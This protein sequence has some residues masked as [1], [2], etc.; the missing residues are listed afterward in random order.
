VILGVFL[1]ASCQKEIP[2]LK[3]F[4]DKRDD[5]IYKTIKIGTQTWMAENLAYLPSVRPSKYGLDYSPYYY[6]YGYEGTSVSDA[7]ATTNYTI[8]GVLYNWEAAKTA[9]PNGWHLPSDTE[10]TVLT[11]YLANN[12][13]GYEGSGDD[14]AKSMASPFDWKSS[15]NEYAPGNDQPTNNSSRFNALPGGLRDSDGYFGSLRYGA[16]FWSS[17]GY[18][19]SDAWTRGLS[20]WNGGVFREYVPR[21]VG[22]YV[23]CLKN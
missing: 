3:S 1:F 12:G 7:K 8:Y 14:I 19:S 23:R 15:R 20:H 11:D 5:R 9:C 6:V 18:G 4:Q 22:L 13:F 2:D 16:G 17:S 21:S 10:W